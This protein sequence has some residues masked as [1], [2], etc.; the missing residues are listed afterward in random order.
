MDGEAELDRA[1]VASLEFAHGAGLTA[2]PAGSPPYL[3]AAGAVLRRRQAAVW[4]M[5]A[6]PDEC[7]RLEEDAAYATLLAVPALLDAALAAVAERRLFKDALRQAEP[8]AIDRLP[9]GENL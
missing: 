1:I 7:L 2:G 5:P 6:D 8:D 4:R 9:A 3:T